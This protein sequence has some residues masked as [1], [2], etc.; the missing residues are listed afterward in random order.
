MT[1]TRLLENDEKTFH[2]TYT[3]KIGIESERVRILSKIFG[4]HKALRGSCLEI[5][6]QAIHLRKGLKTLK[7]GAFY[8]S[9]QRNDA[10]NT[11]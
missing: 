5:R 4:N 2:E 1:K 8:A 11:L 6:R 3:L 7:Q 10:G 9:R